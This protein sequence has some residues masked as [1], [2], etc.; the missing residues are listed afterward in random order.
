[1]DVTFAHWAGFSLIILIILSLDLY[2]AFRKP[3]EVGIK[4]AC[5][6]SAGWI[7]LALLFNFWIYWRFGSDRSLEFLTGFVIEKSLSIDNLFLFLL[8]FQRFQV[9]KETKYLIL[10]YGVLGAICMRGLLIWAGV[11]LVNQ[12]QWIFVLFGL[13]LIITGIRLLWKKESMKSIEQGFVYSWIMKTIPMTG[14]RG[15]HFFVKENKTWKGTPLLAALLFIEFTDL[16]FAL[17]S[18]PAILG[19]TTEPFIVFTSNVFA[20]LGLRSLFFALEG[21]MQRFGLL[22]YALAFILV[23]IGCKMVLIQYIHIP[24][25]MTFAVILV[26]LSLAILG[27]FLFPKKQ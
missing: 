12:F 1:M 27:S 23:F 13:F 24:I 19:I 7:L 5:L 14:Y 16:I 11:T 10:F 18:V 6:H 21:M 3:R 20:I 4:E 17:D 8:I 26:V 15:I 25:L 2:W 22:H 9:P